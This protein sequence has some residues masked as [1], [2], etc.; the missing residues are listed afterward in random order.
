[1][2]N[3]KMKKSIGAF[4][5][6]GVGLVSIPAFA[7]MCQPNGTTLRTLG[8][9]ANC[10]VGDPCYQQSWN[11]GNSCGG[12]AFCYSCTPITAGWDTPVQQRIGGCVAGNIGGNCWCRYN[13]RGWHN[14]GNSTNVPNCDH[15]YIC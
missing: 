15:K 13:A 8:C 7:N 4:A 2:R 11:L 14:S 3:L 5:L 12:T 6:L 10:T 9:E 1:M